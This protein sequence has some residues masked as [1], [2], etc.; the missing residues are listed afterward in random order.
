MSATP[1]ISDF[2]QLDKITGHLSGQNHW[3][4]TAHSAKALVHN[5]RH[6]L[7][8]DIIPLY[9]TQ[10]GEKSREQHRGNPHRA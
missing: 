10:R 3:T 8:G 5:N 9:T 1:P 4:S 2:V 6:R 7:S